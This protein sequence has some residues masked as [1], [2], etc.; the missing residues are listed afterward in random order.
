MA[1]RGLSLTNSNLLNNPGT[2]L[3]RPNSNPFT[4]PNEVFIMEVEDNIPITMEEDVF[5]IE[6]HRLVVETEDGTTLMGVESLL[7]A[8]LVVCSVTMLLTV[9]TV[10]LLETIPALMTQITNALTVR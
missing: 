6:V 9:A 4:S 1:F 7:H 3:P 8:M 2:L 5:L 10:V